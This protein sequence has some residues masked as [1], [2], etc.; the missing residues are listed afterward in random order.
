MK[1]VFYIYVINA[2]A[3]TVYKVKRTR[4]RHVLIARIG[5]IGIN[6]SNLTYIILNLVL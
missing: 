5:L 6:L 3:F 2:A 1:Y 4:F